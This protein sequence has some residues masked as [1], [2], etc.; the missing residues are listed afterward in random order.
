MTAGIPSVD[1]VFV[2][3]A[4][5]PHLVPLMNRL[6]TGGVG[7]WGVVFLRSRYEGRDWD[8]GAVV[9]GA[10][11]LGGVAGGGAGREWINL[12]RKIR[13]DLRPRA[14]V[15]DLSWS[16]LGTHWIANRLKS[17]GIRVALF[18]EAPSRMTRGIKGALRDVIIRRFLSRLDGLVCVTRET[19]CILR[20]DFG[21][22]KSSIVVPYVLDLGEF[23]GVP[24]IDPS[25]DRFVVGFLGTIDARK[26]LDLLLDGVGEGA[27]DL[28]VLVGGDGPRLG[29]EKKRAGGSSGVRFLGRV[30]FSDRVGFY[31]QCD[32]VAVPSRWD[33]FGTTVVEGMAC[34]RPV[35]AN[36]LAM[37]GAEYI[38]SGVNGWVVD[39]PDVPSWRAAID[40]VRGNKSRLRGMGISARE[41]IR[42]AYDEI[43]HGIELS[44]WMETLCKGG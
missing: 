36:R 10:E 42:R 32:V 19:A 37:A 25:P 39:C 40:V 5:S 12:E 7:R 17:I 28:R 38:D 41:K 21:F 34:A 16:S 23:F 24:L 44:K 31:R 6:R 15:L 27:D 2:S 26:G 9:E 1:F 4:P 35:L 22:T 11:F 43:D 30:P 29:R 14:V 13:L 33:G 20:S 18:C 8:P 3:F